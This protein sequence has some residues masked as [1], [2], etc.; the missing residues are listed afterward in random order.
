[1]TTAARPTFMSAKGGYS[2]RDTNAAPIH[3]IS[4]RDL[5]AHTK[6]KTRH[7]QPEHDSAADDALRMRLKEAEKEYFEKKRAVYSQ[8]TPSDDEQAPLEDETLENEAAAHPL[9]LY[10]DADDTDDDESSSSDS[11]SEDDDD[12][13][14]TA[15]L[16]MELEKIKKERALEKERQEQLDQE[17]QMRQME[18]EAMSANPLLAPQHIGVKRRWDDDVI[19]KHQAKGVDDKPQK[20]FINDIIRSDFHRKFMS[21]YIK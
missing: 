6:L 1:M 20:R 5:A 8:N 19:F 11:S 2:L 13:D 15:L 9:A 12:D 10:D 17:E 3:Q 18:T 16:L 14:D 7:S 4:A 21:K